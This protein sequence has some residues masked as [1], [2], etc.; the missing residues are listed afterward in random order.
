[1]S[2]IKIL[3]EKPF[4]ILLIE[5]GKI[6]HLDWN[7]PD[8]IQ[9]LVNMPFVKT[10][11]VEPSKFFEKVYE[12]LQIKADDDHKHLMTE[13]ISEEP[14]YMYEIIFRDTLNKKTNLVY[15]ELATMLHMEHE[16]ING[17]CIVIK[18]YIPTLSNDMKF[19]D[20]TS[21]EL[22]KVLRRRG[23]TTVVAW[24]DSWRE[25]EFYGDLETYANKLFEGEKYSKIEIAF[26]KY[27]IN[28]WYLKSEY[29]TKDVCG[30]FINVPIEKCFI[31]TMIT[32]TIRGCITKDEVNKILELSKILTPPFK[33]DNKWFEEEKDQYGRKIIKNKYRILDNV[34]NENF[35]K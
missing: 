9:T 10:F 11:N 29:G 27:N 14:N 8:Y 25:D 18:S 20:M 24:E 7:S 2:D 19:V 26:L 1:M 33:P 28:I 31:F 35:K 12:L 21:S 17:N 34:Y 5:P 32:D 15:N 23:F 4:H 16:L 6:S 3:D 13:C 30:T 22:H